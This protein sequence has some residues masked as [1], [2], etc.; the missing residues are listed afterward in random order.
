MLLKIET[1]FRIRVKSS[2]VFACTGDIERGRNY[3]LSEFS[4]WSII[5]HSRGCRGSIFVK[6]FITTTFK[7]LRWN[8]LEKCKFFRVRKHF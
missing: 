2:R 1:D 7:K 4:S 8:S 5:L 6:I 3:F